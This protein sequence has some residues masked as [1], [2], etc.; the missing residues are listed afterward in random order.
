MKRPAAK[1][2][3]GDKVYFPAPGLSKRDYLTYLAQ[4]GEHLVRHLRN[5]PITLVRCPGGVMGRRFY[6]RHL[7][8]HAPTSL[9][10]RFREEGER[11]LISISDVDT[12]LYY[13]NL[14]AV[15]FHA[16]LHLLEGP[17]A[18]CPT[19]LTFDLDPSDPGDFERVRELALRLR[20]VLRGLEL[21]GL[22]KTTGASGLQVFVP[23][24]HPL[25]YAVTRPVVS[26]IAAYCASRWPNLATTERLVRHRGRRVYVDA[27][28]HGP[29]RTLIAAYSARAVENALVSVPVTWS[30]L[31]AGVRPDHFPLHAV[32]DRLARMGDLMAIAARHPS[33]RVQAIHDT[34]PPRWRQTRVRP[35]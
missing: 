10:R 31:E 22:P 26:F 19:A 23:L 20:D 32:P 5:R 12:L 27:P 13:G 14:G 8:P 30:E 3:H 18:G 7:P 29:T 34:L 25:P 28:Q 4:I 21:D 16:G 24:A 1:L 2:T 15:E 11:P 33:S 9:P 17:Q 35:V 6:Q